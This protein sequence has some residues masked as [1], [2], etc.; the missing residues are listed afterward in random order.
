MTNQFCAAVQATIICFEKQTK[1][2]K[3]RE[4]QLFSNDVSVVEQK[5]KQ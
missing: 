4:Y 1:I 3:R 2:N 5:F